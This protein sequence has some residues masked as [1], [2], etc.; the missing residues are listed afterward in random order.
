[1]NIL[2]DWTLE[3]FTRLDNKRNFQKSRSIRENG[4]FLKPIF[5]YFF[6]KKMDHTSRN[7]KDEPIFCY[8]FMKKMDHTSRNKKDGTIK[9]TPFCSKECAESIGTVRLTLATSNVEIIDPIY[10]F[11]MVDFQQ[12]SHFSRK[13][14]VFDRVQNWCVDARDG[15]EKINFEKGEGPEKIH[16]SKEKC[17]DTPSTQG[18]E[19][20]VKKKH[21]GG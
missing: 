15:F 3:N 14:S 7:K 4:H 13:R 16:P 5:C 11:K 21:F 8:F 9:I 10:I 19:N 12:K 17:Q 6:M 18:R 2:K 20:K 1:M